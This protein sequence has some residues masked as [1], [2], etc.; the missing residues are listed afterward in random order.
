MTVEDLLYSTLVGSA[1]NTAESLVRASG[2]SRAE[3][4][5]RMNSMAKEL[6][7]YNTRFVEPS[8]L[9][10]DNVSSAYDYAIISREIFK[11]SLIEKNF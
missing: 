1:N 4:V 2:L 5:A 7:A 3:F 11:N 10:P 9:S 8:G 6:G